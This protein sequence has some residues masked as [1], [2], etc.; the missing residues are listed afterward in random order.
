MPTIFQSIMYLFTFSYA[1]RGTRL[2]EERCVPVSYILYTLTFTFFL[3]F[4]FPFCLFFL[5]LFFLSLS[6]FSLS[7]LSFLQWDS[8]IDAFSCRAWNYFSTAVSHCGVRIRNY[9]WEDLSPDEYFVL[10]QSRWAGKDEVDQKGLSLL[11]LMPWLLIYLS[12]ASYTYTQTQTRTHTYC[13]SVENLWI[14]NYFM[15][16][17]SSF[18][19]PPPP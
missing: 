11:D 13:W 6:P 2:G 16:A 14:Q 5:S 9:A 19:P 7:P 17:W 8:S 4:S 12:I 18:P 1:F 15:W 10:H 3:N